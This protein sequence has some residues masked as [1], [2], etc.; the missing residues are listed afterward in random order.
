MFSENLIVV[1]GA[2]KVLFYNSLFSCAIFIGKFSSKCYRSKYSHAMKFQGCSVINVF[3]RNQS[4]SRDSHQV[5]GASET[6]FS[7]CW[8]G[9]SLVNLTAMLI[10]EIV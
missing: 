4:M 8:T 3:G 10:L 9:V 6:Y 5:K 7:V 1:F 2:A